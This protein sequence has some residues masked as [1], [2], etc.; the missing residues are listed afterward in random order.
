MSEIIN[1][2][3][4]LILNDDKTKFLAVKNNDPS[5]PYWLTP[6]GKIEAGETPEEALV[7]EIKEELNCEV[8]KESLKYV[9]QY[10]A[11]AAG[12]PGK[13]LHIKLYTGTFIGEPAASAEI[14][15]IGWLSKEDATNPVAS[16]TIRDFIIPD[17]VQRGIL[18]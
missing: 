7:R 8:E 5:V 15:E 9:T 3:A 10:E 11:P 16:E 6:G 1:K 2:S 17:L 18:L 12:K 4:L 13:I 14:S